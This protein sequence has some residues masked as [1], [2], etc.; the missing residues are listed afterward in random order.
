MIQEVALTSIKKKIGNLSETYDFLSQIYYLPDQSSKA[1]NKEYLENY[2]F[3]NKTQ[4]KILMIKRNDLKM[5][6]APKI[7]N[8]LTAAELL[9]KLELY[10]KNQK[11][12]PSGMNF[13]TLPNI[14]WLAITLNILDPQDSL[15]IFVKPQKIEDTI[16]RSLNPE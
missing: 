3:L 7:N 14:D 6:R 12:P 13:S 16:I 11:L 5:I 8:D 10:L 4:P 2:F 9:E 1:I 15:K